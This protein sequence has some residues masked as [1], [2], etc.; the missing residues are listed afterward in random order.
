MAIDEHRQCPA[1]GCPTQLFQAHGARNLRVT[2]DQFIQARS[3]A[4]LSSGSQL[5][6]AARIGR[7]GRDKRG[8]PGRRLKRGGGGDD[9]VALR[10]GVD[11]VLSMF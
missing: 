1:G 3:I 4:I 10:H 9:S 11:E 8:E 5:G 6:I 2:G 7:D